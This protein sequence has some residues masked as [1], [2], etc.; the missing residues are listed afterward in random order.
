METQN[1]KINVS[2]CKE[3]QYKLKF[4]KNLFYCEDPVCSNDCPINEGK[5]SCQKISNDKKN[6]I[7]NNLCICLP[8]WI[9]E[10]CRN[11]NFINMK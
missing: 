2:N 8:G 1:L 10:H 11:K 4:H 9:G 3:N 6:S 5:A 7:S